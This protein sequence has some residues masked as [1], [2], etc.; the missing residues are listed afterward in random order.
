MDSSVPQTCDRNPFW[1]TVAKGAQECPDAVALR[2]VAADGSEGRLTYAELRD[3]GLAAAAFLESLGVTRESIVLNAVA[4]TETS[5]ALS[6]A[7]GR[8]GAVWAPADQDLTLEQILRLFGVYE[9]AA[10]FLM[11]DKVD[12]VSALGHGVGIAQA[13]VLKMPLWRELLD[14]AVLEL[15]IEGPIEDQAAAVMLLTSGTTGFP[16][17]VVTPTS[18]LRKLAAY[19]AWF[20]PTGKPE[21]M[22]YFGSPAWISYSCMS[23]IAIDAKMEFVLGQGYRKELF[24]DVVVRHKP[25]FLFFWPEVVVDFVTLPAELQ[26]SIASFAQMVEYAGARTPATALLKLIHALPNTAITQSYACSEILSIS[27]LSEEDHAAARQDAGNERAVRRLQ[28]A[29]KCAGQVRI[30]DD[31]GVQVPVGVVGSI[32]VVP[33]DP[34]FVFKGY[35]RNPAATAAKWTA[36]GWF[37]T[38][39]LGRLDEDGYLYVDGRDSETIVL[40]SGDNVY[41][42]EIESVIAELPGVVEVG[43]T[44]VVLGDS[45]ISEVGAFVRVI[46]ESK[47]TVGDVR[48]QCCKRLGQTWSHPT[49]IFIQTEKLPRN[50]NGKCMK[51]LLSERASALLQG[52]RRLGGA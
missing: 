2:I 10:A 31:E 52:D 25:Q 5:V 7:V 6:I 18:T 23:L 24:F 27:S 28:S 34:G 43:V 50:K 48:E 37:I 36:D 30:V 11:D 45:A 41:P 17:S 13:K 49:H 46:E 39:D 29:G 22:V 19:S 16:K 9:P 44:K 33:P 8:L 20:P 40:L 4:N 42:N 38:G 47:L 26:Q 21:A 32:Q 51:A 15:S 14:S 1:G 3:G 35:H 12:A